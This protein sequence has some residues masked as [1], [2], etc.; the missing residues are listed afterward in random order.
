MEAIIRRTLLTIGRKF[1]TLRIAYSTIDG[2]GRMAVIQSF[3]PQGMPDLTGA[4]ADLTLAPE[5]FAT[6]EA[7]RPVIVQDVDNDPRLG[8]LAADVHTDGAVEALCV[9]RRHR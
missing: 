2:E 6:L 5:Y 7:K 3:Q 8:P 1:P 9:P 4:R